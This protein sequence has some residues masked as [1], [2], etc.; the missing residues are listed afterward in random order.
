MKQFFVTL[1]AI[2]TSL[3]LFVGV[4]SIIIFFSVRE[5]SPDVKDGSVLV[6]DLNQPISD[7]PVTVDP[8]EFAQNLF[9]GGG[10]SSTFTLRELSKT[11]QYAATDD[12]I[13]GLYLT[14]SVPTGG[15]YYSGSATLREFRDAL[16]V[17]K[18]SEKPIYAYNTSYNM[19]SYYLASLADSVFIHPFG[20]VSITG[21]STSRT[22]YK[23]AIDR[24]GVKFYISRVGAYKS[25]LEPYFR[26]EMSDEDEEQRMLLLDAHYAQFA[27]DVSESRGKNIDEIHELSSNVQLLNDAQF[28]LEK[29]LVDRVTYYDEL[30][31]ALR[32]FTGVED[33]SKP[34]T[35][36]NYST[37]AEAVKKELKTKSDQKIALFYA[38]GGI[39]GG[40]GTSDVAADYTA[41]TL[42]SIRTDDDVKAVVMRVN[43][44]G[45]GVTPS[46]VILREMRLLAEVKPVIVSMGNVAASGGYWISTYSDYI[47]AMPTTITGSIGVYS[48]F[49]VFDEIAGDY[50]FTFDS[51]KTH[52]FADL[53]TS[54]RSPTDEEWTIID[55]ST[56]Q[57]YENFLSRVSEG[58]ELN[59]DDVHDIA[60][61]RVWTGSDALGLGLVDELGG[62]EA[63]ILKAAEHAEL[64]EWEVKTYLRAEDFKTQ[65][66]KNF[67][68]NLGVAG[69]EDATHSSRIGRQI[70]N[71]L[72][73]INQHNDPAGVYARLPY[74]IVIE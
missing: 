54:D 27:N 17:F 12:R 50:G 74:D 18:E 26:S 3:I 20:S 62:L 6:L 58:R 31:A 22:F 53:R 9:T 57:I 41:R 42:R 63:A 44:P 56:K 11:I 48:M 7:R 71:A 5:S 38:E 40:S 47:Y 67:G 36:I 73:F 69:V 39:V 2:F 52:P 24:F 25:A 19:R 60:Q 49:P 51:I 59:R 55:N 33:E 70:W 43:S 45:G 4:L 16:K 32:Q 13:K 14:G 29:G 28:A 23:N 21:F 68:V 65:L 37:Y 72:S 46:E 8:S 30:L 1:L 10:I 61:G 64:E 35:Q 34:F 66:L 15:T